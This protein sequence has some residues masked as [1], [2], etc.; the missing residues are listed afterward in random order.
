MVFITIGYVVF[1]WMIAASGM[2][3]LTPLWVVKESFYKFA[4]AKSERLPIILLWY[5]IGGVVC[6][7]ATGGIALLVKDQDLNF[8]LLFGGVFIAITLLIAG[9][10]FHAK[11]KGIDSFT[12]SIHGPPIFET[13]GEVAFDVLGKSFVYFLGLIFSIL[14]IGLGESSGLIFVLSAMCVAV[15]LSIAFGE[16]DKNTSSGKSTVMGPQMLLTLTVFGVATLLPIFWDGTQ[17][18]FKLTRS[19]FGWL[20]LSQP[21][22]SVRARGDSLKTIEE[23]DYDSDRILD[24]CRSSDGSATISGV[25]VLWHGMGTRS[26]LRLGLKGKPEVEVDSKEIAVLRN[27]TL[28]CHE[29]SKRINFPSGKFEPEDVQQLVDLKNE[30][31]AT[32]SK[33]SSNWE[34]ARITFFGFADPMVL[35]SGNQ[36]LSSQRAKKIY[37]AFKN[38]SKLNIKPDVVLELEPQGS[39][40]VS[41]G[42]CPGITDMKMLSECY[43]ADRRVSVKLYFKKVKNK[44]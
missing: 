42:R 18:E 43:A 7:L 44:T 23:T 30:F 27:L 11:R 32:I 13:T 4:P 8:F 41:A 20:G 14:A 33:K 2:L 36:R 39:R 34:L 19:V 6:V 21:E 17:G 10:R 38:D 40:T 22:A 35:E 24:I 12:K 3:L 15:L 31:R 16:F 29:L 25:D 9:A 28:T 5:V 37:D 26:L 1:F